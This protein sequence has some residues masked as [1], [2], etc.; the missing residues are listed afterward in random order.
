MNQVILSGRLTR[1]PE[2]RYSQGSNTCFAKYT[3]AVNRTYRK[4]GEP[5]ADFINCT[6]FGKPAEFA[7]KY[8]RQGMKIEVVGRWQTGSYTN[9]D[10]NKVYTNDCIVE[11]QE[12]GQSKSESQKEEQNNQSAPEPTPDGYD[13]F[14]N[15]PDGTD[16]ELPFN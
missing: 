5:T 11:K 2:V 10:G 3:L 14:M 9:K 1:D 12:F 8:F 7:E 15:I 13:G 6:V 4:E 16:E